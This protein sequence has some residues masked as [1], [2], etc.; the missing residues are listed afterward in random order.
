MAIGLTPYQIIEKGTHPQLVIAED[1]T[2]VELKHIASVQNGFAFSSK[3]FNHSEGV[4]L[5][6]IR[7]IFS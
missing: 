2:R 6:R 1:W 7:D 3:L 4:P 5:I